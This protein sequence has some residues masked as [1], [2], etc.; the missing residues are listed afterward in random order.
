M[1]PVNEPSSAGAAR[2]STQGKRNSIGISLAAIALLMSSAVEPGNAAADSSLT[3]KKPFSLK[4]E[5][6]DRPAAPAE[7]EGPQLSRD[8]VAVVPPAAQ[9]PM[10][11][12][13]LG[14][15]QGFIPAQQPEQIAPQ[16]QA[17]QGFNP[18]EKPQQVQ[19]QQPQE[20]PTS[21]MIEYGVDWSKWVS[22]LADRWFY[23][24]KQLEDQSGLQFHTARPCL[25]KFTCYSNGA[26]AQVSLKQTSGIQLYDQLQAQALLQCQPVAPFPHGTQRPSFTLMQGWESHPR[27]TGEHDYRPGS[28]GHGFPVE[29]V[30]QWMN[31]SR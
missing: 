26:I 19:Q 31:G 24:L 2:R 7:K 1:L 3:Q 21:S 6:D 10:A 11:R 28:F 4:A 14:A 13:D 17:H 9:P 30:K 8:D 23:N 22:Q 18:P 15:D 25:I 20:E 29:I 12:F 5:F 27:K 16:T